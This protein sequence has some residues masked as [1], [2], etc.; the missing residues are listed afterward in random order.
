MWMRIA[1]AGIPEMVE[2]ATSLKGISGVGAVVFVVVATLIVRRK[3]PKQ[4]DASAERVILRL[5]DTNRDIA[6]EALRRKDPAVPATPSAPTA[7][8][9]AVPI[10]K[11][12]ISEI[13]P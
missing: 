3:M 2:T 9:T 10:S 5:I 4:K 1:D 12:P 13:K 6:L 7:E 11:P 8:P